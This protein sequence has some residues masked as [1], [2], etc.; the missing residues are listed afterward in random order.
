MS[1]IENER[2]EYLKKLVN[3]DLSTYGWPILEK[4]FIE[5]KSYSYGFGAIGPYT[6][7]QFSNAKPFKMDFLSF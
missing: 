1:Y 2:F 6:L 4:L 3:R 7:R 5:V